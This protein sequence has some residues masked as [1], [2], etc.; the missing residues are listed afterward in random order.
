MTWFEDDSK[1]ISDEVKNMTKA[2]RQAIISKY[3][4]DAKQNRTHLQKPRPANA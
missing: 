4:E 1:G 2:Q 3:E